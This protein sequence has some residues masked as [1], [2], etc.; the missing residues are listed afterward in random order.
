MPIPDGGV[1][2]LYTDGLVE[3]RNEPFDA[4][5]EQL[6][7]AV[8]AGLPDAVCRNV[9]HDLVGS[10]VPTDDIAVVVVQRTP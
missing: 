3:R 2:V 4:R 1:M 7:S 10:S 8:S 6:R 9:L 5:F